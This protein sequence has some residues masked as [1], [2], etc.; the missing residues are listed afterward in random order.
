VNSI[1]SRIREIIEREGE[2]G[3]PYRMG[4]MERADLH[5]LADE[6]DQK[7][8]EIT[9]IRP[10]EYWTQRELHET[11]KR[12]AASIGTVVKETP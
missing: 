9:A 7:A 10:D 2:D 3:R 6:L 12:L 5:A 4:A 11:V 8:A 1:A